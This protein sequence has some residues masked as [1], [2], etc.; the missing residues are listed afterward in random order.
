LVLFDQALCVVNF[1]KVARYS[2]HGEGTFV[3]EAA[4]DY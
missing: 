3:Q 4:P 1:L 2:L